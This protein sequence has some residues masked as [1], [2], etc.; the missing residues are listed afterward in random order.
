MHY[1]PLP[2][3]FFSSNPMD[4]APAL[5]GAILV[6]CS[7][8][9]VLAARIVEVEAYPGAGDRG[10]H[11]WRGPTPR[12]EVMFGKPGLAYAYFIYGN[13]WMLNV[14]CWPEGQGG[15]VLLRGAEPLGGIDLMVERRQRARATGAP[16]A[17]TSATFVPWLLGGPARLAAAFGVN[18]TDNGTTLTK[19]PFFLASG[20][21]VSP[22]SVRVS[23]R[24]GLAAGKGEDLLARFYLAGSAGVSRVRP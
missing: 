3:T 7:T 1:T 11:C 6:R 18:R 15:A 8:E 5:L 4:V 16:P 12:T 13:Y 19:P 14:V 21:P 10:S 2:D 17:G 23:R 9:G 24:I 20:D 22:K